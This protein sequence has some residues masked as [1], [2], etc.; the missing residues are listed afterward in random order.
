[1]ALVT[2]F[3]MNLFLVEA[4]RANKMVTNAVESY[5]HQTLNGYVPF[6][7]APIEAVSVR[8]LSVAHRS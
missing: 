5:L 6:T 2:L 7:L 4:F 8:P 1:V 3:A